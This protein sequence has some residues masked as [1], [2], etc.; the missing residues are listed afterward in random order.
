MN[1]PPIYDLVAVRK[2]Q[3]DRFTLD[4]DKLSIVEGETLCLVGPTGAGKSTLLRLLSGLE[5]PSAG[6][7]VLQGRPIERGRVLLESLRR[8][9]TV[10]QR[11]LLLSESVRYNVE[12]GLRVRGVR[13]ARNRSEPILERLGLSRFANQDARTL[14]GGQ[15]QLVALGRALVVESEILLLDEPTAHLDPANVALVENLVQEQKQR[16]GMTVVW[17]THNLFQAKRMAS[18]SGL[19]L[20]GQLIEVGQTKTFFDSPNDERTR[21]F[22]EGK[23]VY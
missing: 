4:I 14:S 19:L 16:V 23:M 2:R 10:H 3:S 18:R 7:V 5:M 15:L 11:P 8:I 17:A 22:V 1:V 6:R 13:S 21:D 9:A 20:T 12:F